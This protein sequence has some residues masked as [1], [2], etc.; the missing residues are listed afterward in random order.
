MSS[1]IFC[2][3]LRFLCRHR[4][5]TGSP[6][7]EKTRLRSKINSAGLDHR[8]ILAGFV[9]EDDLI[10]LYSA[11]ELFLYP[12][13]YEGFGLPV[14]EAMACGTPVVTSPVGSIPEIAGAA[15]VMA[16]PK[17]IGA[18]AEQIRQVVSDSGLRERL[19]ALGF[20]QA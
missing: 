5:I 12:S 1:S 4:S 19:I 15:A 8:V 2:R 7:A 14:L 18:I 20:E 13:F 6:P 9:P 17:N 10:S 3:G 16:Y 11:A